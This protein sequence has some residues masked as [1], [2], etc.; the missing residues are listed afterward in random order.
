MLSRTYVLDNHNQEGK[1]DGKGLL[2][3]NGARDEVGGNVGAHDLQHGGLNIGI[4]QSL[5]V[6]VA[7]VLIPDLQRLGAVQG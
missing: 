7:D 1:L 4:G 2:G 5:D 6:A 3:V